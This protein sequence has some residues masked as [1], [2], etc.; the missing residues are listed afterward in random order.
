VTTFLLAFTAWAVPASAVLL[1]LAVGRRRRDRQAA[2]RQRAHR[3]RHA[4]RP[5]ASWGQ[6]TPDT[7]TTPD[8]PAH[9]QQR[10]P[11]HRRDR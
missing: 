9:G 11:K 1:L 8:K 3:A 7:P 4:A 10:P 6:P 2:D 5:A